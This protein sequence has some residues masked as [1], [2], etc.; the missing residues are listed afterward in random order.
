MTRKKRSLESLSDCADNAMPPN[1]SIASSDAKE[2]TFGK[3]GPKIWKSAASAKF[4]AG[5]YVR[6]CRRLGIINR[7]LVTSMDFDLIK[8]RD[9]LLTKSS[10]KQQKQSNKKRKKESRRTIPIPTL[11]QAKTQ[12]LQLEDIESK[13]ELEQ[14]ASRFQQVWKNL[15]ENGTF[16]PG[17]N[18][19]TGELTSDGPSIS[20]HKLH[21]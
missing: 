19:E 21:K 1:L 15:R 18:D 14:K 4:A 3:E 13:V 16:D 10:S 12:I 6:T 20:C 11:A 9:S 2:F 17:W 7:T 8:L 5:M